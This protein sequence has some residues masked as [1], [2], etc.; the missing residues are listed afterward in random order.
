[1]SRSKRVEYT[2]VDAKTMQDCGTFVS[3]TPRG[4]AEKACSALHGRGKLGSKGNRQIWIT[5]GGKLH[6]YQGDMQTIPES[7]HTEFTRRHNITQQ[8]TVH[9]LRYVN[10]SKMRE[11]KFRENSV[12]KDSS[13]GA[14]VNASIRKVAHAMTHSA[15]PAAPHGGK[16]WW[17]AHDSLVQAARRLEADSAATKEQKRAAYASISRHCNQPPG[18]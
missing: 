8:P 18:A 3:S 7:R 5:A 14:K 12:H 9:K 16:K 1:M 2:L 4:A 17:D 13:G 10:L 11:E 15:A 6:I